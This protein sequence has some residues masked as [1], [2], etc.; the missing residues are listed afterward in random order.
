MDSQENLPI[1]Q[2]ANSAV[3][4]IEGGGSLV[5]RGLAALKKDNDAL[6][7]QARLVFDRRTGWYGIGSWNAA[8]N[9]AISSAFKIFQ[10]L[11]NENYG[12][13]YY[14]LSILYGSKHG[15]E[16]GQERAQHFA[17]LAF[18]W[19]FA[20]QANQDAELWYDLGE[21]Y[22]EG[23]GVEQ[24]D[25]QAVY[26]FRMAAEQGNATGQWLLGT[27]YQDG[28]GVEQNDEQAVHWFRKAAEQGDEVAQLLLDYMYREGRGVKQDEQ[29][30][31]DLYLLRKTAEQGDEVA[32]CLLGYRYY[33]G[34]GVEQNYE[35]AVY[36]YRK[37]AEQGNS[38]GQWLLGDAYS[39]GRG[40][41]R[42]DEQAIDWYCKAAEHDSTRQW[43]LGEMCRAGF[44]GGK[45]DEQAVY[46]YRKAAEQGNAE[47]QEALIKLGF[48]WKK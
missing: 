26:W 37:S 21:M 40:V 11:A 2:A 4:N 24:N 9:P 5:G 46:W 14:P 20:N 36:W 48:D 27:M 32:Q 33:T 29:D 8:D 43:M 13:A 1:K 44:F 25:V 31:Q 17:Q 19:C 41:E 10:Q 3:A 35:Q 18:D 16:E 45:N 28:R 34:R 30:E 42:N 39:Y 22:E 15:I 23:I 38:S 47:A 6:Y 12:K 7:R